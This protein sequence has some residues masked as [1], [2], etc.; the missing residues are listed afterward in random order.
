M[1]DITR[2]E[3]LAAGGTG[4][5]TLAL[6]GTTTPGSESSF[7][8]DHILG[9][10][11]DGWLNARS[12]D[13]FA[14][15]EQAI[16]AEVE[17]LRRVFSLHDPGSE[18]SRWNRT[19]GPLA[20]SADLGNVLAHYQRFHE[21][22]RGACSPTIA[23]AA[24]LW[25]QAERTGEVPNA[26]QLAAV[27]ST[28]LGFRYDPVLRIAERTGEHPLN[29]NSIA[30]G[31]IIQRLAE[32]VRETVPSGLINLG[33]DMIAWG[34][35]DWNLGIQHPSTPADNAAPLAT[36]SLNNAAVATSGGYLRYTT[37][38]GERHSHLIDP[39]TSR[40][41]TGLL[42]A[43][44]IASTSVEANAW[45]TSLAVMHPE[46]ALDTLANHPHVHAALVTPSGA[47]LRTPGMPWIEPP[48]PQ[49][50][51]A[52]ANAWPA[53]YE[54]RIVLEL[55]KIEAGKYR[56]PYVAVWIEDAAGKP[57]RSLETWGN[58]PK[59]LKD[60]ND[61]WKFARD[62]QG[63]RAV[64]RATRNPGR[65][66]LVWDGKDQKGNPLGQGTYTVKVEVHREH[67][68]HLRQSGKIECLAKEA[69][70][71]L[72]KNEETGETAVEYAKKKKP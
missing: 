62:D 63:M 35:A 10:S 69:S 53:D 67:G 66:E 61:W 28:G 18:L 32:G 15:A 3:W 4:I 1:H 46:E 21:S 26:N 39:R 65:Y 44:V 72:A 25:K 48:K 41:A 59:Y 31:Y 49:P 56:R 38:R 22:T 45:A 42:S 5:A 58:A 8:Y 9:T 12:D 19:R 40:P 54:V 64:T 29:L 52:Q 47:V 60:L 24:E 33:G 36:F 11:L 27:A 7:H 14:H 2:R 55:P 57:V 37:I 23:S 13:D 70:V 20:V 71:K 17:R 43:T 16:L 50:I 30:K 34:S 6:G 51:Q 68:R